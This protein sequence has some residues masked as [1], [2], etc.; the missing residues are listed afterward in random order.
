MKIT[1]KNNF[2]TWCATWCHFWFLLLK[3]HNRLATL[4]ASLC[5]LVS[6]RQ[7]TGSILLFLKSH[8]KKHLLR[9]KRKSV[10][11][12][13]KWRPLLI[14][15]CIIISISGG[16]ALEKTKK[17]K[18][19]FAQPLNSESLHPKNIQKSYFLGLI[20]Q[21]CCWS[22]YNNFR[23]NCYVNFEWTQYSCHYSIVPNKHTLLNR[24]TPWTMN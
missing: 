1:N 6:T 17:G 13:G 20:S 3:F 15:G 23:M 7:L 16:I 18:L 21:Q 2:Q 24:S 14:F 5:I 12:A 10:N 22:L 4:K 19:A 8:A 11:A 9:V